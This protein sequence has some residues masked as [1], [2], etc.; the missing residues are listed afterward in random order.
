MIST[1]VFPLKQKLKITHQRFLRNFG[2][3]LF[4]PHARCE[5]IYSLF[6]LKTR[7]YH[8]KTC[9]YSITPMPRLLCSWIFLKKRQCGDFILQWRP[10]SPELKHWFFTHVHKHCVDAFS[11]PLLL[12]HLDWEIPLYRG[13]QSISI[14]LNHA[15]VF[16]CF[17]IKTHCI[18]MMQM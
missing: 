14:W 13:L 15:D 9:L 17:R 12:I 8:S 16:K 10:H 4:P 5:I 3:C 2:K 6:R 18:P 7:F 1:F 11:G